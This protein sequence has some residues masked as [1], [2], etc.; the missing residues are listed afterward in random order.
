MEAQKARLIADATEKFRPYTTS[1]FKRFAEL[2]NESVVRTGVGDEDGAAG[3]DG[4]L[5][6]RRGH[7]KTSNS[8]IGTP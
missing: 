7:G 1:N 6:L 3:L 8:L 5:A 4:R 2:S